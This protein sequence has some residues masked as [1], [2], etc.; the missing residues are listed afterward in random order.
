MLRGRLPTAAIA[1]R[2]KVLRDLEAFVAARG[3]LDV[4]Q[5]SGGEPLLHPDLLMI[6]D[7]CRQLPIEQVV[8]NTNGL[9]LADNDGSGRRSWRRAG[10]DCSFSCNST[11]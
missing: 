7:R 5:L 3:P 1:P 11:A 4:L 8:I 6:I 2:L 9:E 10:R